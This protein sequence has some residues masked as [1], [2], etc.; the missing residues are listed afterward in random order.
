MCLNLVRYM[1]HLFQLGETCV[2]PFSIPGSNTDMGNLC[3]ANIIDNP[4]FEYNMGNLC[5]VKCL[6]AV[7]CGIIV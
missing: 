1:S 3:R 6:I 2:S 7:Q 5:T 4:N